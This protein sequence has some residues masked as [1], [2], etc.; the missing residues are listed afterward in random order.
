MNDKRS[1]AN[2]LNNIGLIYNDQKNNKLALEY[3]SKAL[4]LFE[5]MDNKSSVAT[6]LNNIGNI[7]ESQAN[8]QPALDHYKKAVSIS[9]ETNNQ[10]MLGTSLGNM[11]FLYMSLKDFGK[12]LDYQMRALTIRENLDDKHGMALS[13]HNIAS[14]YLK[15]GEFKKAI[16][17]YT[18]ELELSEKIGYKDGVSTACLGLSET[19]EQK[20]EPATSLR[21]Y[22][23]YTKMKDSLLN[24]ETSKQVVEMQTRYETEKKEKEIELQKAQ[25]AKKELE[26]KQQATQKYAFVGGFALMIVLAAIS[27]T[28]Y[29]AKQKANLVIARQKEE[30]ERK[31]EEVEKQKEIIE[32]KNKDIVDS[33][34]YAQRIQ[35][36]I[37]TSDEY[38]AEM[39]PSHFVLFKPKDIVSGDFYWAYQA[40]SKVIWAVADCTG[41][42][43]PGAFMSM[44]GNSFLNEI[45]VE[46]GITKADLILNRLREKI[47]GA[48]EQKGSAVKQKDGM[49]IALCVWDRSSNQLEFSG[50]NNPCWIIRNK[51]VI[52]LKPDKMP[53][54]AYTE[55]LKPFSSTFLDLV[56]GD[57]IYTFTDGY[58]D[59]FGG[60]KGKKFKYSQ[61]KELLL[62]MQA[63]PLI[64]QK[65][66]LYDIIEE[67]R[68]EL[69]QVDD[70]CITGVRVD[71]I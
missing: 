65:R 46:N 49:D 28:G 66:I 42:G 14:V 29:R 10:Q 36:A 12:S 45:V 50:A 38:M 6:L 34:N 17:Y 53:I 61:M 13:F 44:I 62:S 22:K 59:Q 20:G 69:E 2:A 4:K 26:V 1:Q 58:A 24:T 63:E 55:V 30:V 70:I 71:S 56:K 5:E 7:Y 33:I 11:G 31:K 18:R 25:I 16:E 40:G 60:P 23:L 19:F 27:Y 48:L 47:I 43:V 9:E 64:D 67:W 39:F 57:A 51:D 37:L 54:G 21:Y 35:R 52:E 32:E 68:G 8:Y 41:H 15:K 3:Y